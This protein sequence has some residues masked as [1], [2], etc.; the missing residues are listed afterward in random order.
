MPTYEIQAPDGK[1]YRI[2]GPDGATD[3]Q[4]RAE[5]MR[6]NQHLYLYRTPRKEGVAAPKDPYETE[7]ARNANPELFDPNYRYKATSGMDR[8]QRFDAGVGQGLANLVRGVGQL[9]GNVSRE[10]IVN[11][12]ERDRDL[13]ATTSGKLGSITGTVVGAAPTAFIPGANTYLGAAGI[14][15]G[16]GL[17]QPATSGKERLLNTAIGGVASPAGMAVGRG[18]MAGAGATKAALIDPF[19]KAGQHRI[20]ERTL[21]TMAGGADEAAKAA[22]N[23]RAGQAGV[24]P[25]VK[26]TTAEL[27]Q[28]A[29][30]SNLER[31]LK[32]NPEFTTA[33]ANRAAGNRNAMLSAVDSIAGDDLAR[34]AAVSAREAAAKPLYAAADA[35]TVTPDAEL[36]KILTRPSAQKAVTRAS[37]LAAESGEEFSLETLSGRNL[38]LLKMAMDDLADAPAGSGIGANEARSIKGTRDAL[39][40][41]IEKKVPDYG[42]AREA[43]KAG[44]KPINQMDVGSALRDKLTPALTDFGAQTRLRPE[45]F[46]QA[47]RQGDATAAN[48]LGR[49][50]ASI[51]DIMSPE[52][53]ATLRKVGEQLA[54]RVNADE[55][56]KAVGSNTG[57]NLVGQ[58]VVRQLLGPLGLPEGWTSR[59]ASSPLMTGLT[60]A[61]SKIAQAAT[62]TIGEPNIMRK[63]VELGL[64]PEQALAILEAQIRQNVVPRMQWLAPAISGANAASQ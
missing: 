60:G 3:E 7:R 33:F 22:Q 12:R 28:N 62:G 10:D 38:H 56:G 9:T 27:A 50:Q 57:Q 40:G 39:L 16:L 46:A 52:Q 26:P 43:F 6:Q 42:A 63:L 13:M 53:M 19:T 54:R 15:A 34:N 20:A 5:V 58:N 18:V 48:V 44:S 31:I 4:I 23:I 29:G 17:L 32:N 8:D 61:P 35:A 1:K 21:Q 2:D 24:L 45:S 30:L 49:S 11:S 37:Q 59:M 36:A 55:L 51:T 47:L 41:W 14:G 64:E 25:G